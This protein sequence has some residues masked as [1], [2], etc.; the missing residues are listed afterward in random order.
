MREKSPKL[1]VGIDKNYIL[2][3]YQAACSEKGITSEVSI[4]S[5]KR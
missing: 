4:N 5:P 1:S 3:E 2:S